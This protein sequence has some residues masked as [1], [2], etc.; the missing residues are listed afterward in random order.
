MEKF[1]E[2]K[3]T[4]SVISDKKIRLEER[5]KNEKTNLEK[6]LAEITEKGYDP[7]KL[8]ETRKEKEKSLKEQLE[9]LETKVSETQEKLNLIEV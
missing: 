7:K 9:E 8:T 1:K 3:E 6:L 4:I 2:L 5:F